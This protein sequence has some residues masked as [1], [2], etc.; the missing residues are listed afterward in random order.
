MQPR[1][2]ER[3]YILSVLF[4]LNALNFYDRQI[5]GAVT[6]PVRRELNL[7]DTQMG[8]LATVF[9][10]V[11]AVVGIPLGRLADHWKRTHLL[12]LSLAAWSLL[13]G[14]SGFVRGYWGLLGTRLGVGIGE[15][16]CAPAA[17]SLIG[18][19]F[20]PQQRARALSIFMLGLPVG[21]FFCYW[22]SG[23]LAQTYGWRTAFYVAAVPGL[24]LAA[25]TWRLREPTRGATDGVAI[26]GR[27]RPG[28]PWAIV[29][30]IPTLG[31]IIL[32]GALFN[33]NLYAVNAFTVS[34][35]VRYHQV[36]V[37]EATWI[38]AWV[39][40]AVGVLGL[41]IGGWA[42]DR[43]SRARP[44]GRLQLA[45][46][47]MLISAPCLL[48]A[49]RQPSGAVI[50]FTL[51]MGLGSMLLF[52]YYSCVYPA[53]QDVVE[54][55]LRG[56]AMALYF[57]AMYVLGGSVGP[58]ATGALSDYG[59]RQAMRAAGE[60]VISEP[61]KAAGLHAAMHVIPVLSFLLVIVLFAAARTVGSDMEK[62]RAWMRQEAAS[63]QD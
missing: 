47:A 45:A 36:S 14:A 49:L 27:R 35:L 60:T 13:T 61:F 30:R 6:E 62:L 63:R 26:A 21:L 38:T 15:A 53:I 48:L 51:F 16:A 7:N 42:S 56:T 18:D 52:I 43:L 33:F 22:I 40:G 19:L 41:L 59:A 44:A 17:N 58:V 25:L 20:P 31:W 23:W 9:T 5:L 57:F 3:W 28:S 32:S 8:L 12:A 46:V 50:G 4:C 24:I 37:R 10:L 29:F 2:G 39:L 54:P 34:F 55:T 11:Y 1:S